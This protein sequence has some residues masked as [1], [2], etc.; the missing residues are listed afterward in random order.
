MAIPRFS[1]VQVRPEQ[2]VMALRVKG[3]A[4]VEALASPALV[5]SIND[6]F[7]PF[8]EA[9]NEGA[10]NHNLL[11]ERRT[12]RLPG[13]L[14]F[15]PSARQLAQ[16]P[17]VTETLRALFLPYSQ[18]VRLHM[19]LHR[20]VL[21]GAAAQ[22]LHRDTHSVPLMSLRPVQASLATLDTPFSYDPVIGGHQSGATLK[23]VREAY[24]TALSGSGPTVS[25]HSLIFAAP[26]VTHL[27][28]RN[29]G[30]ADLVKVENIGRN[31]TP[32]SP[33]II[34]ACT[35]YVHTVQTGVPGLF[36]TFQAAPAG[37]TVFSRVADLGARGERVG[38]DAHGGLRRRR[39][40]P[41]QR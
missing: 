22:L 35:S 5:A 13:A 14:R 39:A 36:G 18:D 4:I 31:K 24:E 30:G 11:N 7:K 15:S 34:V 12:R 33:D 41:G 19:A 3:C 27:F 2:L 37:T 28:V 25:Q 9:E 17:L 6:E 32:R 26:D 8:V 23:K 21:P 29:H 1:S 16:C 10:D 40:G 20:R 38:E